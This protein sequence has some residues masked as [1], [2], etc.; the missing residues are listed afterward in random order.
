MQKKLLQRLITPRG[1]SGGWWLSVIVISFYLIAVMA[2]VW[3]YIVSYSDDTGRGEG[4]DWLM[5][6][7]KIS[8]VDHKPARELP[9][10]LQEIEALKSIPVVRDAAAI[11]PAS[12]PVHL[13]V[14]GYFDF[15]VEI[16]PES[17]PDRFLEDSLYF[18]SWQSAG[19]EVP[20]IVPRYFYELFNYGI[21]LR[22]GLPQV[23]VS[24]AMKLSFDLVLGAAD[25]METYTA[26][27]AGF[28]EKTG[29]ILV[30]QSF[31]HFAN[32]K[33]GGGEQIL[34]RKILLKVK[35]ASDKELHTCLLRLD[36]E[37]S[38]MLMRRDYDRFSSAELY[39]I[40]TVLITVFLFIC[41]LAMSFR[42]VRGKLRN[43]QHNIA[44]LILLG[45]DPSLLRKRLLG[46]FLVLLSTA[47]AGALVVAESVRWLVILFLS[48][49]G[50]RMPVLT[51]YP[52][53]IAAG[54]FMLFL[55]VGALLYLQ[56]PIRSAEKPLH[57]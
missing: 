54:M 42:L 31:M 39:F 49:T 20:I 43:V 48:R 41:A 8:S 9:F 24:D 25:M 29:T 10:S 26:R 50:I 35:D 3:L 7:R 52:V 13:S 19:R 34:S 47:V 28:S 21:A 22:H 36:Y 14:T 57:G 15:S 40:V 6:T 55:S 11:T 18:H 33:Y 1:F 2:C 17:L 44:M 27:I 51:G 45:Y 37:G 46:Q 16:F 38:S 23:S 32:G 12:F 4:T 53:W 56:K 30:P 5:V